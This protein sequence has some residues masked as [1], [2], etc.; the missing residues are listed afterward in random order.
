MVATLTL[1]AA[2]S[3]SAVGSPPPGTSGCGDGLATGFGQWSVRTRGAVVIRIFNPGPGSISGRVVSNYP[4][5]R[6]ENWVVSVP[7]G[8]SDEHT[9]GNLNVPYPNTRLFYITTDFHGFRLTTPTYG[10]EAYSST[11]V[12]SLY[13]R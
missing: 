1:T 6:A 4:G 10:V 11:C 8:G 7:P 9:F 3:A 5:A 13:G 2:P 12:D